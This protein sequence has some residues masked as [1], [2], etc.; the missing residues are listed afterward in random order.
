MPS[1]LIVGD[2]E[3]ASLVYGVHGTDGV[4]GWK[5]FTRRTGLA[6]DWEA[7]E[8]ARLPPGGIS[9]E[10]LHTRTEEVY[11]VVSGKGEIVL[12]GVRSPVSAGDLV[13]TGVGTTHGLVNTGDEELHWLVIE[14]A[15]PATAAVLRAES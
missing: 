9:G 5:C 14:V 3:S 10:H 13:L 2:T 6:G 15:S 11:F 4:S 7:V 12:N 1:D 8:W